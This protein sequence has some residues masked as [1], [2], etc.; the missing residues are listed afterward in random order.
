MYLKTILLEKETLF[1]L[2]IFSPKSF[3]FPSVETKTKK[4]CECMKSDEKKN[5]QFSGEHIFACVKLSK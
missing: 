2:L 3:I 5:K 1:F 4:T